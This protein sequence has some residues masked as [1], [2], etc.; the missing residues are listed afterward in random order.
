MNI[1]LDMIR[2]AKENEIKAAMYKILNDAKEVERLFP[3]VKQQAD[4]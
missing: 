4:Y 3:I 1:I 2:H